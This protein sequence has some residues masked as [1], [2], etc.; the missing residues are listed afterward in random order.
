ME[1]WPVL[2]LWGLPQI[3]ASSEALRPP[4][5]S[6][7]LSGPRSTSA[8]PGSVGFRGLQVSSFAN[9]SWTRTDGSGWLGPL[10]T[11]S[12]SNGSDIRCLRPWSRGTFSD[13]Q[14]AQQQQLFRVY[15]SSFTRDIWAFA[16]TLHLDYP[17]EVQMSAGC[18]VRP[19]G[20]PEVFLSSAFQG[21]DILSFQG[22]FWVLAPDAPSWAETVSNTLNKDHET[23]DTI[24]WLLNDVCPQFLTG[25]LELGQQE[26]EKQEKPE[27]WLSSGPP[28]GPGR[29]LL[30]CHVSGFH[31]EPVWVRWMQGQQELP[32]AQQG[33]VLPNA[34][35]TW[36]LR[37]TLDVAAG[38][39]AGLACRVRHSSLGGQDIVLSWEGSHVPVGL[40]V[41]VVLA[42][43]LL[44]GGGIAFWHKKRCSYQ[45]IL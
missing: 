31:P 20:P 23:R 40:I 36:Y 44:I 14:W 8:P 30:V 3:W 10:Q 32:G 41:T 1:C 6:P 38:E 26:L 21:S 34:D 11:H 22:H 43:L 28:P 27:A 12:W 9:S 7:R 19:G 24:H 42:S 45:D 29:L 2:L 5:R 39:A 13:R 15:R 25:L 17:F 16:K 37:V 35:G 33:D 18:E 4:G